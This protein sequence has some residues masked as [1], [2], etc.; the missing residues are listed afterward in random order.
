[1]YLFKKSDKKSEKYRYN[2]FGERFEERP[3]EYQLTTES[4]RNTLL[5]KFVELEV[6]PQTGKSV[7]SK[8]QNLRCQFC[9]N[10]ETDQGTYYIHL[11]LCYFKRTLVP[12]FGTYP[13]LSEKI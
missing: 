11:M 5:N 9:S 4:E 7:V 6:S 1:M 12:H 3:Y 8:W 13:G 2:S 10:Y